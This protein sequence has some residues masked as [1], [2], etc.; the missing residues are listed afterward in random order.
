M[1]CRL[2]DILCKILTPLLKE[3]R[4]IEG[5]EVESTEELLSVVDRLNEQL[6]RETQPAETSSREG[7]KEV[8]EGR[9]EARP[10]LLT[11]RKL[12]EGPKVWGG[13]TPTTYRKAEGRG[14]REVHD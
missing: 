12:A 11:K 9:S 4:G 14:R 7:D 2:S 5:D 10:T 6:E 1:N 13:E 8:V 3:K